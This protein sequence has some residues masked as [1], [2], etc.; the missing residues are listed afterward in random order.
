MASPVEPLALGVIVPG[1]DPIASLE[2]VRSLGL[3]TC[4]MMAPDPEW[5]SA[6]KA[7]RVMAASER[8]GVA[9]TCIFHHFPGETYTDIETIHA[10]CGLVPAAYR[11]ERLVLARKQA[12]VAA[13]WGVDTMAAHIGFVPEERDD[14]TYVAVV[15]AMREICDY[16]HEQ[17]LRFGLETGQ[18]KSEALRQFIMDVNRRNLGVNFDPANMLLYGADRPLPS[19]DI[20]GDL[21]FGVHA[22][23]GNW[24][25]TP[26]TLGQEMPLGQ[27]EVNFPEFIAKL[28][29]VGYRGPLTIEREIEGEQQEQDIRAGIGMLRGLIAG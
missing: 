5:A 3:T 16:E 18:E 26:G 25:A 2:R 10:M 24:P 20:L 21:L 22:K 15:A 17:G 12:D 9:V 11:A 13:A 1:V 14:P 29:R 27:G 4:Q 6:D 7:A 8:T 23:D 19:L 28:K